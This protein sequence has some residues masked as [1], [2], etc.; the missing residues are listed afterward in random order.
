[1]KKY[2]LTALFSMSMLIAAG[3][4]L[5][6]AA[7]QKA[8]ADEACGREALNVV[9]S[10]LKN[11]ASECGKVA[12]GKTG[13]EA[14]KICLAAQ[15][16]QL[17]APKLKQLAN[18]GP[19]TLGPRDLMV[20]T[21]QNGTIVNPG[22]RTFLTP[23]LMDKDSLTVEI[24]KKDGR[25]GANIRICKISEDKKYTHLKTLTFAEGSGT[26]TQTATVSGIKG[27]IVQVFI[28]G[29]GGV[30]KAFDYTLKTTA[31]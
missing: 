6:P 10:L 24:A 16:F 28:D 7:E 14:S 17:I 20:G 13:E 1:M 4:G 31:N 15:K 12:E 11:W 19:F 29:T 8:C 9:E 23:T 30:T 22:V 25:G 2:I 21:S 26:S 18:N 3:F 27:H 5:L